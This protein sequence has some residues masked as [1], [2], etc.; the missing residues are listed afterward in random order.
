MPFDVFQ[1]NNPS[2]EK[3][4]IEDV[5]QSIFYESEILDTPKCS[6]VG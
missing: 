6:K 5:Q 1:G 2:R 4:H 3:I